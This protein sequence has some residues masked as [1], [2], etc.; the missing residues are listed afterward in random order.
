VIAQMALALSLTAPPD[1]WF[2][3]DKLKHFFIAAFTQTIAYSALQAARVPHDQALVG[4]WAVTATVS[5]AKEVRDRRAYG[6]FSYRDLVWDAAGA[7]VATLVIAKTV[8]TPSDAEP[9]NAS[10]RMPEA[11]PLLSRGVRGPILAQRVLSD[12]APRR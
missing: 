2:G 10:V 1:N 6:L 8:R 4:A 7:G 12:P 9:S 5:V 11:G 3:S